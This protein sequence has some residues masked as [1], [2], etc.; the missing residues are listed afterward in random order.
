M[1]QE[2]DPVIP[3]GLTGVAE[4][5]VIEQVRKCGEGAIKSCL[6]PGPP[7]RMM[8][9]QTDVFRGNCPNAGIFE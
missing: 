4:D 2:I 6:S 9:N 7:I 1:Q 8:E 3:G 5:C